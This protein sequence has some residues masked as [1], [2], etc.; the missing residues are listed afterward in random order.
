MLSRNILFFFALFWMT[1]MQAQGKYTIVVA[2]YDWGPAVSKVI[3]GLDKAVAQVDKDDFNVTAE[4]SVEG[5]ILETDG[6][7][8]I[9]AYPSNVRGE[10]VDKGSFV[11]LV[12][13]IGPDESIASPFH[14][15]EGRN[16]WIDYHLDV[17]Q[18]STDQHWTEEAGRMMPQVERFDLTG[19]FDYQGKFTLPYASFIPENEMGKRPLIIWLHGGGEGGNDPTIPLL[20]NLATNYAAPEIQDYFDGAFVLV[21]QCPGAWMHNAAGIST[22]GKENDIYNEGLM[23]LIKDYVAQHPTIDTDRIYVGGCSNGGYMS[24]KL[25]MLYPDYFAAAFPSASAYKSEYLTDEALTTIK[26]IPIWLIHAKDDPVTEAEDT[27][28]PTYE[29]LMA[30]GAKD[31]H[32]SLFD[33]VVDVTGFFGGDN[34]YYL[35]HFSWVYSHKNLCRLDY[36]GKPVLHQGKPV[37]LMEWLAAQER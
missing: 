22:W 30:L 28:I 11:T 10:R 8:V 15:M 36:D 4:R 7:Q 20:A 14:F 1:A 29:R 13:Q 37:T 6:R 35:G 26:D 34:Y 17:Y 5:D 18:A 16:R 24:L 31:V 21:P 3:I 2:G 9:F 23:A 33:H 19:R 25:L 32:L 27:A 12:L